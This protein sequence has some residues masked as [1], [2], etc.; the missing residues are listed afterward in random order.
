MFLAA[1]PASSC[2]DAAEQ[3][4]GPCGEIKYGDVSISGSAQ[5]DGFFAAVNDI[6]SATA[7]IDADYQANLRAIGEAFGAVKADGSVNVDDVVTAIKGE[8]SAKLQGGIKVVYAPPQC[9][10]DINVAVEATAKC[11]AKAGCSAEVEVPEASVTCSGSCTGSC[12]G[13]CTGEVQC[14]ASAGG[15]QCSGSC[16][17]SCNL[18]AAAACNG[19]CHGDCSG[20][21]EVK[22]NAGKCAG[23]CDGNCQGSCELAVAGECKGSCSG[24][25]TATAPMASCQGNVKCK[26]ECKG[27]CTGGCEGKFKPGSAKVDCDATADCQANASAQADAKIECTPPT[28]DISYGFKAGVTAAAQADFIGKLAILKARGQAIIQGAG[29]L[30]ALVDGTVEGKVV[31]EVSPLD[32]LVASLKGFANADAIAKFDIPA[33]RIACVVPA[34]VDAGKA[35]VD[36]GDKVGGTIAGQAKIVAVLKGG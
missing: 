28:L 14:E 1:L 2:K 9:E 8:F 25:C 16:E 29:K 6:T 30:S 32:G 3:A 7:S 13:E 23:K 26:G 24:K 20:T 15:I 34:F 11:E 18:T 33:G 22:D 17:G 31:Y 4:C 12:E 27:S 21:C 5:L 19:T 10:A 35:L 36:A